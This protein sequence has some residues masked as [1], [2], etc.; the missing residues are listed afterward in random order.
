MT[1]TIE[2]V[3][4]RADV[5]FPEFLR[6]S[7]LG[8]CAPAPKRAEAKV[9]KDHARKAVGEASEGSGRRAGGED[10]ERDEEDDGERSELLKGRASEGCPCVRGQGGVH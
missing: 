9:G 1:H 5:L 4:T 10:E 2:L 8:R 3:C 7:W 6:G